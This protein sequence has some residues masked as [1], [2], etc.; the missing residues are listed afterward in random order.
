MAN[1]YIYRN[2]PKSNFYSPNFEYKNK[3]NEDY[4]NE[5]KKL[6]MTMGDTFFKRSE[7]YKENPDF[8]PRHVGMPWSIVDACDYVRPSAVQMNH[9]YTFTEQSVPLHKAYNVYENP[10]LTYHERMTNYE[11]PVEV[12]TEFKSSDFKHYANSG[13]ISK[14][15]DLSNTIT[16]IQDRIA[17]AHKIKG[18]L[19]LNNGNAYGNSWKTPQLELKFK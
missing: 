7:R 14:K 6:T 2:G 17:R 19:C 8:S 9:K 11:G 3:T 18:T 16:S 13:G 12:Q 10:A 5:R 4:W 1:T 15:E